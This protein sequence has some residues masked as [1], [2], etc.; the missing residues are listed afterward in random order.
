LKLSNGGFKEKK[1][2]SNEKLRKKRGKKGSI[3]VQWGTGQGWGH[4]AGVG[5][6]GTRGHKS[7]KELRTNL[8]FW[9]KKEDKNHVQDPIHF[10]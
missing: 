2:F 4:G 1:N 3:I 10:Y 5:A 7:E 9:A 8:H 6:G